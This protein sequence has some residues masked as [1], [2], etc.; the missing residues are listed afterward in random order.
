MKSGDIVIH[1]ISGTIATIIEAYYGYSLQ[2]K[3]VVG[4]EQ[5]VSLTK[6]YTKE[7]ILRDWLH[8]D[9]NKLNIK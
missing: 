4:G 7:E 1:K 2:F 3:T 6:G 5:L 8:I 9:K